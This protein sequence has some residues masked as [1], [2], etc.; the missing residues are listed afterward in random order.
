[1]P[2]ISAHTIS[3]HGDDNCGTEDE[4]V[5]EED[6]DGDGGGGGDGDDDDDDDDD[7]GGGGG[8]DRKEFVRWFWLGDSKT[9]SQDLWVE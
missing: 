1:M 7:D 2:P 8:G 5:D 4:A 3:S 6:D 9:G